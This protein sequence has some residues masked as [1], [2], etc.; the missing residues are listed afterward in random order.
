[1]GL[2]MIFLYFWINFGSPVFCLCLLLLFWDTKWVFEMFCLWKRNEFCIQVSI[3]VGEKQSWDYYFSIIAF[4]LVVFEQLSFQLPLI[5]D[6][7]GGKMSLKFCVWCAPCA[8]SFSWVWIAEVW[9]GI[10]PS[11]L[12]LPCI[13]YHSWLLCSVWGELQEPGQCCC[14]CSILES[15]RQSVCTVNGMPSWVSD[16]QCT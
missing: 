4:C 16:P 6:A 13:H 5:Q 15:S 7:W 3:A 14:C 12:V 2:K 10:H 8:I 1:M 9:A 11:C